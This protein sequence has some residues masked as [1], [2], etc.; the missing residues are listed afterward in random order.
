MAIF[1]FLKKI[2][3]LEIK[4][5]EKPNNIEDLKKNHISF[6]GA[7]FKHPYDSKK[8]VLVS[9]P[10]SLNTSFYE[11][12]SQDISFAEELPNIVGIEGEIYPMA[13]IWVRTNSIG[14]KSTPFIVGTAIKLK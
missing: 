9:D 8:V 10:I 1:N 13:R 5:Y 7:P 2:D 14:I 4:A 6:S 12:L 11:F 3:K